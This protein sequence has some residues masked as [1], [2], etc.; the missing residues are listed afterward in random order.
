MVFYSNFKYRSYHHDLENHYLLP[1]LELFMNAIFL[2][3][4]ILYM[5]L[6]NEQNKLP[7]L[8]RGE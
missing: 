3:Y 6:A 1:R 7:T 5:M 4:S 8:D 2:T